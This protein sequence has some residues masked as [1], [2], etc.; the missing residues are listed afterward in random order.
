MKEM[1]FGQCRPKREKGK[2]SEDMPALALQTEERR[3][4]KEVKSKGDLNS[5]SV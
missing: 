5:L 1:A 2:L 4:R 3:A